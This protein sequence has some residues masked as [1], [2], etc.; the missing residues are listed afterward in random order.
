MRSP[1]G[2]PQDLPSTAAAASRTPPPAAGA[3][4][5][6]S[7]PRKSHAHAA[8]S[9][10]HESAAGQ[11]QESPAS[12]GEEHGR[13]WLDPPPVTTPCILLQAPGG[14]R[15]GVQPHRH[16][17]MPLDEFGR[18]KQLLSDF[19]GDF[20]PPTGPKRRRPGPCAHAPGLATESSGSCKRSKARHHHRDPPEPAGPILL[21][22]QDAG[23]ESSAPPPK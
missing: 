21:D 13:A 23:A 11:P 19:G 5:E 6:G 7:T 3:P 20:A 10:P 1:A 2:Q 16:R 18:V 9:A 12:S 4:A 15:R 17:R 8:E 14:T 22:Y